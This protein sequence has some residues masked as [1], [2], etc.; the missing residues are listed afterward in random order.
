MK[1]TVRLAKTRTPDGNELVLFEHDGDFV[2]TVARRELMNSR[3]H[4]SEIEL[5]RLGC[6][7][8]AGHRNPTV[9]VGGLGM[10]YTLRATLDLLQP[11]ARVVVAEL[12]PEV[13]NWNR[14]LLGRLNNHPLRDRRVTL[15][16]GD[17]LKHL[18]GAQRTYD[19]ILLDIDNGP[20]AMTDSSNRRLYGEDGLRV[21]IDALHAR[22]CLAIWSVATNRQFE[23]RLQ[24]LGLHVRLFHVPAYEGAKNRS[25]VIWVAAANPDNLPPE[26][27]RPQRDP[28][29][30][31]PAADQG[32]P[33]VSE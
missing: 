2:I 20:E 29:S 21:L 13:V 18:R 25:R 32:A 5:A 28:A 3:E 12:M 31:A 7:R 10:G 26:Q 30:E 19:A 27:E 4:A 6:A 11:R 22:G 8:I 16:T 14:H 9:L 17:I 15:E 1:P 24:R 23:R 33:L